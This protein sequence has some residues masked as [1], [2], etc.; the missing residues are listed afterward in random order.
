[1]KMFCSSLSFKE[2]L[3]HSPLLRLACSAIVDTN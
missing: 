2:W 3:D 1:V